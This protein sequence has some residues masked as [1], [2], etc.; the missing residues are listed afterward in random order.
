M[1]LVEG[2]GLELPNKQHGSGP[3]DVYTLENTDVDQAT[4]ALSEGQ[5]LACHNML[6]LSRKPPDTLST[7]GGVGGR[8]G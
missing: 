1:I 5:N 8:Q 6:Q 4:A 2:G 3:G 7:S